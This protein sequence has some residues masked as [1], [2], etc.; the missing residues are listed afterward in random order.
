VRL[1]VVS[2]VSFAVSERLLGSLDLASVP[3]S[4][5]S[6]RPRGAL[7]C[8]WGWSLVGDLS[9]RQRLGCWFDLCGHWFSQGWRVSLRPR[10]FFDVVV[11]GFFV[12]LSGR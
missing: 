3:S 6:D 11:F 10:P 7:C 4:L 12:A 5:V 9:L 2:R 8:P 1:P